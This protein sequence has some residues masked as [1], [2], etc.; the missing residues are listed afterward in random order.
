M[1]NFAAV[2]ISLATTLGISVDFFSCSYLD[3]SVRRVRFTHLCI[4]WV[5]TQR[6]GFPHSDIS[7]SKLDCQLP[8]TFR[9]L[10]RPSS[11]VIA[12][13]SAMCTYSLVPITLTAIG[14]HLLLCDDEFYYPKCVISHTLK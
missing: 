12:K 5:M 3:V 6:A 4:Q 1:L 13:A 10:P 9:R 8:G 14:K 11:P 7:G 2:P